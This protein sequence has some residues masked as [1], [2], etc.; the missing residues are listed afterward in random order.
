[1]F[2]NSYYLS[3]SINLPP[4]PP[5]KSCLQEQV[6]NEDQDEDDS[7][8]DQS[9]DHDEDQS[10]DHDD[11]EDS[12]QDQSDEDKDQ[13]QHK[14]MSKMGTG[15]LNLD[16]L[17][18]EL[19]VSKNVYNKYLS[20]ADPAKLKEKTQFANQ[21]RYRS[22][23]IRQTVELCLDK[24]SKPLQEDEM[25]SLSQSTNISLDIMASF[26]E[27][28][29]H[30]FHDMDLKRANPEMELFGK[31]DVGRYNLDHFEWRQHGLKVLKKDN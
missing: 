20:K 14:N 16:K 26:E 6:R 13:D 17:T 12:D 1:M 24:L 25:M 15:D 18:M 21:V 10:D 19:M 22:D 23:Q 9:D 30:I 31:C 28:V 7:D 3:R 11:D 4:L 27:F 29:R 8:Q 5:N 2:Q